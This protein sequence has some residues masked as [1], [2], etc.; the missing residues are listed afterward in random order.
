MQAYEQDLRECEAIVE[1]L[2]SN[3]SI[4]KSVAFGAIV[5]GSIAAIAGGNIERSASMGAIQGGAAGGLKQDEEEFRV[6][7]NCL[8]NRGYTVLN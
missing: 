6:L 4:G 2:N 1:Q 8:I 7:K 3:E 5:T